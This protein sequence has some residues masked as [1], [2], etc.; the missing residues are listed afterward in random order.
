M[1]DK[2]RPRASLILAERT[3][4]EPAVPLLAH[5]LSKRAPST[6]RPPLH[7]LLILSDT[8]QLLYVLHQLQHVLSPRIR[9]GKLVGSFGLIQRHS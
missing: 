2:R 3:G 4:F 8:T 7:T 5:T 1:E 9:F 6:T